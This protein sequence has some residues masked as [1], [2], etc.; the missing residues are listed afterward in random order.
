M[1]K[2]CIKNSRLIAFFLA[3]PFLYMAPVLNLGNRS[4]L[5]SGRSD[6]NGTILFAQQL[7]EMKLPWSQTAWLGFPEETSFWV[8]TRFSQTIH[9]VT[10]YI[11]TRFLSANEAVNLILLLGWTLTGLLAYLVA[12]EIGVSKHISIAVGLSTQSL[13][14]IREKIEEHLSYVYICVP[15]LVILC[16]MKFIR[17]HSS[18]NIFALIGSIAFTFIFDLFRLCQV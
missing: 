18:K 4:R 17:N 2:S 10:V 9:W 1:I 12:R 6:M 13:P 3:Y 7:K 5:G 16:L 11:L 15:L 8:F 14:W